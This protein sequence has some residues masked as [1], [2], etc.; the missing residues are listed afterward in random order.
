MV[1]KCLHAPVHRNG[2]DLGHLVARGEE[3]TVQI[4]LQGVGIPHLN[5]GGGAVLR[6]LQGLRRGSDG[7]VQGQLSRVHRLQH[8][9]GGHHLGDAGGVHLVIGPLVIEHLIVGG[10]DEDGVAAGETRVL[11]RSG[12]LLL[13]VIHCGSVAPELFRDA[14]PIVDVAIVPEEDPVNQEEGILGLANLIFRPGLIQLPLLRLKLHFIRDNTND[15]QEIPDIEKRDPAAKRRQYPV[16]QSQLHRGTIY[17]EHARPENRSLCHNHR[18]YMDETDQKPHAPSI[19]GVFPGRDIPPKRKHGDNIGGCCHQ[20]QLQQFSAPRQGPDTPG[21]QGF[22]PQRTQHHHQQQHQQKK[23]QQENH[24]S[25][26]PVQRRQR[27][28]RRQI[29]RS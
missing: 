22:P 8:Q 14:S 25:R 28:G 2:Q 29:G 23:H 19:A 24:V 20:E 21:R 16:L 13:S 9:Q 1:H 10:V 18:Q 26:H 6:H 17:P 4:L 27:A 7:G 15:F 12:G 3:Q 5:F 11:H